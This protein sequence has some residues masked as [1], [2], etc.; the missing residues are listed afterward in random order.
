ML[1]ALFVSVYLFVKVNGKQ[2]LVEKLSSALGRPLVVA[3][4]RFVF[5]WGIK[6][7]GL[8]IKG[9]EEIKEAWVQ[10]NPLDLFRNTLRISFLKLD[11]PHLTIHR[12]QEK[13]IRWGDGPLENPVYLSNG[14]AVAA[15][16]TTDNPVLEP[17]E[18]K[19]SKREVSKTPVRLLIDHLVITNGR[20][21]IA[22]Y[23]REK[24]FQMAFNPVDLEAKG[25]S[26][27]W[28]P[29]DT[30]YVLRALIEK[31]G[32]PLSGSRLES[33]GWINFLTK[34]M[35]ST[36]RVSE[37]SGK[38]VL[39]A[40]LKAKNNDVTVKGRL[41]LANLA[42]GFKVEENERSSAFQD[43]LLSGIQS[44]G[45][46]IAANFD[47]KAKMDDFEID[48]IFFSG[49]LGYQAPEEQ[50]NPLKEGQEE[51]KTFGE[52]LADFGK[53]IKERSKENPL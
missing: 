41:Q 36:V 47:F 17:A 7:T 14:A 6:I 37:S 27:P 4:V 30:R 22:D 32:M 12:D 8:E 31:S 39:L 38:E 26:V 2:L 11:E 1:L 10:M 9:L 5:P 46:D 43:I 29:M 24:P 48:K 33:Q 25:I 19:N 42:A 20:L 35:D 3:D 18:V 44:S 34:N 13:H 16:V 53:K 50:G 23:R 49:N 28:E 15:S 51:K 21:K 45:L 40:D 52:H